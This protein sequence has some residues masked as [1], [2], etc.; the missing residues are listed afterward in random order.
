VTAP[1]RLAFSPTLES[2]SAPIVELVS[3]THRAEARSAMATVA[4][5]RAH[6]VPIRDVVVVAR[7]LDQYEEPLFRAAVQYGVTPVFW[8]QL[9]VTRTRPYALVESVCKAL[10]A[11]ELDR[12][13]F[14]R[15]LEHRWTPPG[16]SDDRWPIEPETLY[17]ARAALPNG[18]RVI[19]EWLETL[20]ANDDVDSRLFTFATWL[21]DA[22]STSPSPDL[23]AAVLSGVIDAYA[24]RG[25]PVTE[26][27]DSPALLTT[28]T[29]ARA[30]VRARTLVG[31]LRGKFAER[32][33]DGTLERSW[34]DVADL[35]AVIAT[36]RPGRRE[37][38][39]ARALD[40][41]EA[42]DVWCLDVPYVVAVGLVEGEWPQRTESSIP[43]EF[44]EAV[45]AGDDDAASLAPRAAWTDGRDRAQFA[46]ALGA[47][48]RGVILTR[49]TRRIDGETAYPSP[50][51]ERLETH[52]VDDGDRRALVGAD[53][54]LPDAIEA[55]LPESALRGEREGT[56]V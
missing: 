23:V 49:H 30:V 18:S 3:P 10:A 38:S 21:A 45:L 42:N 28:E 20:S 7:D 5:L 40:V 35:A 52:T 51:L 43:S 47:A 53:G 39:N 48:G 46:D 16:P 50:F 19:E 55:M 37:H 15:P 34:A 44:Q 32:L 41:L 2:L 27:T 11:G 9:R 33:A 54:T 12:E 14:V 56:D 25:L 13:A 24:E 26:A 1:S 36:Q 31:Q 6:G 29:D 17:R 22:P 8:T 4:A